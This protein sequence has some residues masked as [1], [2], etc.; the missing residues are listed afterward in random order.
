M[1]RFFTGKQGK[2]TVGETDL[3]VTGWSARAGVEMLETTHTGSGGAR[4]FLP[5]VGMCTGEVRFCWDAEALA[6]A[7]P[8]GVLPGA[9]L[10]LKLYLEDDS[11]PY[12]HLPTAL[13]AELAVESAVDRVVR[14]SFRFQSNGLFGLFVEP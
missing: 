8:P 14:G 10:E 11:G 7:D 13:V 6:T 5:S 4:S 12:L 2:V 9:E 3:N 1:A